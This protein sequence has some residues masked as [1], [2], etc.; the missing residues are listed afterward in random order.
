M[1]TTEVLSVEVGGTTATLCNVHSPA[2]PADPNGY[3]VVRI[4]G[5]NWPWDTRTSSMPTAT[6]KEVPN[7]LAIEEAIEE[8]IQRGLRDRLLDAMDQQHG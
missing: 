3:S 4:A 2:D 6:P 7:L 5:K 1:M 8:A